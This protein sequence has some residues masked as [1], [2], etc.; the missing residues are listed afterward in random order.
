MKPT[1]HT[2][3][4]IFL[5]FLLS[6]L[7]HFSSI[8][9]VIIQKKYQQSASSFEDKVRE[10]QHKIEKNDEWVETKARAG[11]FGVPVMFV[12]DIEDTP[13]NSAEQKETIP[14]EKPEPIQE[15][16][17]VAEEKNIIPVEQ[18]I[19]KEKQ[20]SRTPRKST[21]KK[22]KPP[23]TL[24]QLTQGFLNHLKNEGSHAI[25]M[26]GKKNGKPS[27]EQIKYE[28]YLE[29]LSWCL[30]NSFNI[31]N[32][33]LPGSA[34]LEDTVHVLLSLN[35]DGSLKHCHVSQTSGNRDLDS[36]TLFIF[37]DASTS[38]PPVPQYLP[39]D[40][41]TINYIILVNATQ[42]NRLQLYRR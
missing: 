2:K 9:Y 36:F 17:E 33:R 40:P 41:F 23:I 28:R 32:N 18:T 4:I 5:A 30:Q 39:H 31:Y 19:V 24:A 3:K 15:K 34:R 6:I 29:K 1:S 7:F 21:K 22:P 8:V 42:E 16:I 38:F 14:E 27:D 26:L 37:K 11:N 35:K 12:D 25:H 10:H 20:K 13:D